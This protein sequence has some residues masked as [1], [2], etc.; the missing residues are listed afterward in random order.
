VNSSTDNHAAITQY[1]VEISDGQPVVPRTVIDTHEVY[2]SSLNDALAQA[3][4]EVDNAYVEVYGPSV[5][6]WMQVRLVNTGTG[7]RTKWYT[8]DALGEVQA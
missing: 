5:A 6:D 3:Y 2:A 1:L 7:K 4:M 8:L